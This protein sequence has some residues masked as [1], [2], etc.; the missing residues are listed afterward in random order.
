MN[1]FFEKNLHICKL[2]PSSLC[3]QNFEFFSAAT[4]QGLLFIYFFSYFLADSPKVTLVKKFFVGREQTASLFCQVE[5]NPKPTISWSHCDPPHFVCDK[6]Y[7]NISKVQTARSNYICTA[8]N[9]VGIDSATTVL[10]EWT[11]LNVL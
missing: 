7:L 2:Q 4:V 10:R 11:L 3:S 8:R 5:G 1:A 9:D 6:Q